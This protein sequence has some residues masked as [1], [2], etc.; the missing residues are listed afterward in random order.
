MKILKNKKR[1]I[2]T[3]AVIL[4]IISVTILTIKIKEGS[5]IKKRA[6]LVD[7][8]D[9]V[10]WNGSLK[11]PQGFVLDEEEACVNKIEGTF[12]SARQLCSKYDCNSTIVELYK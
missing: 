7:N 6:W 12:T 1:I 9:C 2:A 8:C 10:E 3:I 5:E 4:I 11:C